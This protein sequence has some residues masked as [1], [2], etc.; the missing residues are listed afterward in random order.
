ML[1]G[2]GRIFVLGAGQKDSPAPWEE[3]LPLV[4]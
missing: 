3:D 1:W 2:R 4:L